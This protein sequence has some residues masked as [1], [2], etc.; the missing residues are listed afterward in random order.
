MLEKI[1][2]YSAEDRSTSVW[3][4]PKDIWNNL[5]WSHALGLRLFK[6]NVKA[7]YRQ[8][9]LG[10]FWVIFP[11]L[12]TASLW[13]LLKNSRIADFGETSIPYPVH[14]LSGTLIWQLFN[15]SVMS[16]LNSLTINKRVLIKV[17]IPRE[18]LLLSGLYELIFNSIIKLLVLALILMLYGQQPTSTIFY[19]PIGIFLVILMGFSI[20][21]VLSPFGLLYGDVKRLIST[22]LPFLMYLTPVIYPSSSEGFIGAITQYNPLAVVLDSTRSSLTGQPVDSLT[23]TIWLILVFSALLYL[24]L[25]V[26]RSAMPRIIERIGS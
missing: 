20:G 11:P 26:F 5:P 16:P 7:K 8:S 13:I 2:I 12:L 1:T 3:G 18:G 4:T 23:T 21:L 24:G 22:T 6:R 10:F 9:L 14:V 19:F 17:N 25:T 15:E